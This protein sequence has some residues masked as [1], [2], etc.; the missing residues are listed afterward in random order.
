MKRLY[1]HLN[2]LFESRT[3]IGLI[4]LCSCSN[5]LEKSSEKKDLDFLKDKRYTYVLGQRDGIWL[6]VPGEHHRLNYPTIED[7]H[8]IEI[9][10]RS[11]DKEYI[12]V[13]LFPVSDEKFRKYEETFLEFTFKKLYGSQVTLTKK[14]GMHYAVLDLGNTKN[15][16]RSLDKFFENCGIALTLKDPIIKKAKEHLDKD[17]NE[18]KKD[19]NEVSKTIE[20]ILKDYF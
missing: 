2:S 8:K 12:A 20:N 9:E 11:D 16:E 3:S 15:I 7:V 1:E 4:P 10:K 5:S 14:N 13:Q 19:E 18:D 6:Y 17:K